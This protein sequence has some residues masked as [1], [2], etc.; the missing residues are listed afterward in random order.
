MCR[1]YSRILYVEISQEIK[2]TFPSCVCHHSDESTFGYNEQRRRLLVST[3]ESSHRRIFVHCPFLFCFH[4]AKQSA[5][6]YQFV[7]KTGRTSHP[8]WQDSSVCDACLCRFFSFSLSLS[9]F[10][11]ACFL[12][13]VFC[14]TTWNSLGK[15]IDCEML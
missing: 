9:L 4:K 8:M 15:K 3:S 5:Q 12:M 1:I 13:G 14:D 10:P 2:L 7:Q 6:M 11:S